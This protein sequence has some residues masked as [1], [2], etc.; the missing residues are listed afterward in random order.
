VGT[1]EVLPHRGKGQH[2][3]Y[4]QERNG[5]LG[6]DRADPTVF[7]R[8]GGGEDMAW[9]DVRGEESTPDAVS[10]KGGTSLTGGKEET[11]P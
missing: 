10:T 2:A 1:G 3:P 11:R 4:I 7:E 5:V 8:G 9:D 6:E